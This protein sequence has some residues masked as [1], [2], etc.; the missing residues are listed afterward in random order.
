MQGKEMWPRSLLKL[1]LFRAAPCWVGY[2]NAF[3]NALGSTA[4]AT[5]RTSLVVPAT[6]G[7]TNSCEYD[8]ACQCIDY[9]VCRNINLRTSMCSPIY[10]RLFLFARSRMDVPNGLFKVKNRYAA[11]VT[12]SMPIT[13]TK[14]STQKRFPRS[15]KNNLYSAQ[16]P[17][18]KMQLCLRAVVTR[19]EET[20]CVLFKRASLQFDGRKYYLHETNGGKMN[21]CTSIL[22]IIHARCRCNV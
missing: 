17:K 14:F 13:R 18:K 11:A 2:S 19:D 16:V 7:C 22:V 10:A 8:L 12:I 5:I 1:P 9:K 15:L 6:N 3:R 21:R 4:D 20:R